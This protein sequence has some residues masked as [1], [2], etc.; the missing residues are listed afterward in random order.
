MKAASCRA[1]SKAAF[2]NGRYLMERGVG[3]EGL[4]QTR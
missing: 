1:H 2:H 4:G 3:G